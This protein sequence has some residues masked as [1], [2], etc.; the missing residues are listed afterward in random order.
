MQESARTVRD[1]VAGLAVVHV[2]DRFEVAPAIYARRPWTP[3][4]QALLLRDDVLQS[5]DQPGF[6][7]LLEVPVA[8]EVLQVWSAWR[9]DRPPDPDEAAAAVIYYAEHDAYQPVGDSA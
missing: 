6:H 9:D 3:D 5:Q 2:G 7:L 8:R 1:V 4:G